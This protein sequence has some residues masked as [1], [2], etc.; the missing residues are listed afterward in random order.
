[1]PRTQGPLMTVCA[2]SVAAAPPHPPPEGAHGQQLL[3][4]GII[5]PIYRWHLEA[6]K[7]GSVCPD[8]YLN[9]AKDLHTLWG[10]LS[11]RYH[12]RLP[13]LGILYA[14]DTSRALLLHLPPTVQ[15]PHRS[16]KGGV[17]LT[18][19]LAHDPLRAPISLRDKADVFIT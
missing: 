11:T 4:A 5:T 9:P 10:S 16:Q 7:S 15:C 17:L 12:L 18:S 1:M 2:I 14:W 8:Y 3:T 13:T 6:E 19:K